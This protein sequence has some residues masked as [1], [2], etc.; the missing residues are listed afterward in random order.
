[1]RRHI[2]VLLGAIALGTLGIVGPGSSAIADTSAET[3]AVERFWVFE[4]DN[5]HDGAKSYTG[6]DRNFEN[7]E[8]DNTSRS[9][10][11]GTSSVINNTSH[12]VTLYANRAPNGQTNCTGGAY[13]SIPWTQDGDLSNNGFDNRADCV[14]F[15]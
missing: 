14:I 13:V 1:M 5:F 8:W 15:S 10:S 9:V 12:Y 11:D 6:N 4:G 2:T 7:D 3:A